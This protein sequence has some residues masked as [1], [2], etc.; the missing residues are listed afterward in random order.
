M[1]TGAVATAAELEVWLARP[2][3]GSE[4]DAGQTELYIV[5]GVNT[6]SPVVADYGL[7]LPK[8]VAGSAGVAYATVLPPP[9]QY[10]IITLNATALG[11]INPSGI[12]TFGLRIKGDIDAAEP[13][14]LNDVE[15]RA[16]RPAILTVTYNE[17][18]ARPARLGN[19][20]ID[21][22]IYQHAE[23]MVR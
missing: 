16:S 13:T 18:P 11:W 1:G 5:E 3:H 22:L 15:T 23:R 6:G 17:A 8:V 21:Q 19:I 12:T 7:L 14:G 2:H 4:D 10:H 20:L 9:G